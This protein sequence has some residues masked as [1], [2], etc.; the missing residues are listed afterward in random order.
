MNL[1]ANLLI[2]GVYTFHLVFHL[3]TIGV[4]SCT[5]GSYLRKAISILA[6]NSNSGVICLI[7]TV[8]LNVFFGQ[9]ELL[10]IENYFL[11]FYVEKSERAD[12]NF[13]LYC[14]TISR[15][16]SQS[17]NMAKTLGDCTLIKIF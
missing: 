13:C 14:A 7:T 16:L 9:Q 12:F 6:G 3:E 17:Y 4:K 5:D 2:F 8:T 10:L 1:K 11:R 15:K